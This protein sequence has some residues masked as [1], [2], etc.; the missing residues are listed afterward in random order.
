MAEQLQSF[1]FVT[2]I[3]F[4]P[5][6]VILFLLGAPTA[7]AKH[8][9]AERPSEARV[10]WSYRIIDGRKCWYEGEAG[11]SKSSLQW[12]ADASP[13]GP[14]LRVPLSPPRSTEARRAV[15]PPKYSTPGTSPVSPLAAP[16]QL[17]SEQAPIRILTTKPKNLLPLGDGD[18]FDER[19]RALEASG[20]Y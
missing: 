19:W 11:L 12:P 10:H 18:G 16:A 3:R 5:V 4:F 7:Q 14:N 9:R 1:G 17:A 13:S 15:P 20:R 6:L 2:C 8:C